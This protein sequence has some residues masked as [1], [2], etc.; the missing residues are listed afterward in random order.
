MTRS[1]TTTPRRLRGVLLCAIAG[2]AVLLSGCSFDLS[3]GGGGP[4]LGEVEDKLVE[5]Q[6][7]VS[8]HLEVGEATCP[9]EVEVEEGA[10][11]ECTVEI[12][13]VEAAYVVTLTDVNEDEERVNFHSEPAR[14]I[15]DVS[16]VTEFLRGNLN[17]QSQDAE[18]DCGDE[19]VVVTDVGATIDCTVS[20]ERG[21]ETVSLVVKNLQGDVGFEQ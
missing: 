14:P 2:A 20:D 4:D 1:E 15:I 3:F 11:F 5:E 17:E 13:G 18:V 16:A 19:A 8:P 7:K 6:K 21:S 12:E 10:E 9:D